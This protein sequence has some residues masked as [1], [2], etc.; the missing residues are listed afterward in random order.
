MPPV[1]STSEAANKFG[2][3]GGVFT[4]SILTIFGVIMFMRANYVTGQ[5]GVYNAILILL[6]CQFI[7]LLT[8]LSVGAISTNIPVKGGGAYFMVSRVLGSEFG[9][10][11][12]ITLFLAQVVSISFYML[13]FTEA[14]VKAFPA[15][16]AYFMHIGILVSVVLFGIALIG[17]DLAIKTQYIIMAI[18][19]TSIFVFLGGAASNFSLDRL[20]ENWSAAPAYQN[21][22]GFWGLY[23]IYF[24]SVTGFI[25]GINMSGDLKNPGESMVK[26]TLYALLVCGSVYFLQIILYGGGFA[27]SSLI[28]M[29]FR[30]MLGNALGG[31][32]YMVIAGVYAA[33][34]SSALGRFVGAP[35][36]LQAISVD[37]IVP[38]LKPFGKGYG[39]NN[40]PRLALIFCLVATIVLL[41][42]GGD[43]SG[44]AFLNSIAAIMGMFFLYTFGLLNFAAFI[45]GYSQ[46]PSFR[47]KFRYFHW[48]LA[49]LGVIL[50]VGSAMMIDFKSASVALIILVV[51]II[52]LRNRKMK[53]SFG[54]VR[55]GFLYS[56][57]RDNLLTL[58]NMK[59]DSRNWRPSII[60]LSGNPLN[61]E[62]LVSYAVWLSAGRGLIT[63]CNMLVGTFEN[64]CL[65]RTMGLNQLEKFLEEKNIQAFP[66][67]FVSP[68]FVNGINSLLQSSSFGPLRPN[69]IVYGWPGD[70][71]GIVKTVK[72][73]EAADCMGISQ[74]IVVDRGLPKIEKN[75]RIDVWWRGRKNGALMMMLAHLLSLNWEW[76]DTRIRLIREIS[77][78]AGKE[79][80]RKALKQ[81]IADSRM[82]ADAEVIVSDRPF[83][84]VLKEYSTDADAVFLGFESPRPENCD[85]WLSAFENM[86]DGLPTTVLV[87]SC[88]ETNYLE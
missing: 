27:R 68:D 29:P 64:S 65:H 72:I 8:T 16:S 31:A 80:T 69:I 7:T 13:G 36:V 60:A 22:Y 39:K 85:K 67:V 71:T 3:F 45:E 83:V 77:N 33:T 21:K 54:D 51:L 76:A 35:R 5:A 66:Q 4:P 11:I 17:A 75:K 23:A 28:D 10:A 2:T 43:G 48:S 70:K 53:I 40:E 24:P 81:L 61:R 34:L 62:T 37:E 26:G 49:L 15:L 1:R 79:P 12:G 20:W 52:Y 47:P 46:N 88:Q 82:D 84:E 32:D 73:A 50:S 87:K 86:L 74:V 30:T 14:V 58:Q 18:L 59:E 78:E 57:I 9:G 38:F 25:A 55:R 41:Y 56:R 44:G 6:L 19:F 42:F 63:L